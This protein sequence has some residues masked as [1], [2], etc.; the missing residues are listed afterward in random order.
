MNSYIYLVITKYLLYSLL[1][2]TNKTKNDKMLT[3]HFIVILI[4]IMYIRTIFMTLLKNCFNLNFIMR[5]YSIS[6]Q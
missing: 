5:K 1:K 6:Y 4:E 3:K 2:H